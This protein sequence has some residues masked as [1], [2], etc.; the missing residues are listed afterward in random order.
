MSSAIEKKSHFVV[1]QMSATLSNQWF[2]V[3]AN[4]KINRN[5]DIKTINGLDMKMVSHVREKIH[6]NEILSS[7]KWNKVDLITYDLCVECGSIVE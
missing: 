6:Q 2:F 4:K 7:K 3:I 1:K 5:S